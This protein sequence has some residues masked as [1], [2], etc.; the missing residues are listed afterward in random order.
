MF[1]REFIFKSGIFHC[2]VSF[3][4]WVSG[5][6]SQAHLKIIQGNRLKL[7][8]VPQKLTAFCRLPIS[9]VEAQGLPLASKNQLLQTSPSNEDVSK[10]GTILKGHLPTID[11]QGIFITGL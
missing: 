8:R 2:H 4:G 10:K 3:P 6:R 1:N 7:P 11:F 9:H 5:P